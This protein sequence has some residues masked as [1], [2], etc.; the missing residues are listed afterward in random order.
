MAWNTRDISGSKLIFVKGWEIEE[1]G[2]EELLCSSA[3]VLG[4][5]TFGT[6]YKAELPGKNVV[7]VKRLKL[8][9]CLSEIEF[10]EKAKQLA[11]MS[12]KNLLPLRAYCCHLHERLL[13]HD[14]KHIASLA[15]ALHGGVNYKISPLT[16]EVRS[17]I[18]YGIA[19][20]ISYLH[21]QGADVCHGNIKSS[22]M[23]TGHLRSQ[24]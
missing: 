9:G 23:D 2:L 14:Y 15:F 17:S 8:G 12:H 21:S 5:G 4:K 3:E 11:R 7:A 19:R 10:G 1:C 18:A 24:M 13:L 22:N 6:T 16:W 20:G